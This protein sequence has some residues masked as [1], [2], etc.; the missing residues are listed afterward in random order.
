[1]S[2]NISELTK[3]FEKA[4]RETNEY[5]NLQ[6]LCVELSKNSKAKQLYNQIQQIHSHLQQ[7]QMNGQKIEERDLATL[8][9]LETVAQQ[10]DLIQRLMEADYHVNMMLMEMNKSMAKPLEE[11]Y[12]QL[13]E[14]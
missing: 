9:K 3:L 2:A 1:M 12:G 7:K 10:N 6:R 8:Q 13:I 14:N 4:L 5:K 11:V